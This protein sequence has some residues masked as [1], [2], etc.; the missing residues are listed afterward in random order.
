MEFFMRNMRLVFLSI[1]CLMAL[2]FTSAQTDHRFF[3]PAY[4][5]G[6]YLDAVINSDTVAGGARTDSLRVYV[7]Y[8][9]F[10]H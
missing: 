1:F 3:V 7:L 2:Q 8:N 5:S 10:S 4:G 9:D 6:S